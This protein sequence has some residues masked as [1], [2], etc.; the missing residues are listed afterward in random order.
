M[1]KPLSILL[2]AALSAAV[3]MIAGCGG[4]SSSGT[5]QFDTQLA[6]AKSLATSADTA[7]APLNNKI[8]DDVNTM[9]VIMTGA[10]AG[11][12][13]AVNTQQVSSITS[14]MTQLTSQIDAVKAKYQ[15][16]LNDPNL[17]TLKG[18]DQYVAY[19]QA[20]IKA[21]N[22]YKALFTAGANFLTQ[23]E[24]MLVSG[25]TAGVQAAVQAAT[26]SGQITQLQTLM[27]TAQS[28][29]AAARTIK[30]QQELGK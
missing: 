27:T 4:G 23:I 30:S 2:I 14:S 15:Q 22:D 9:T 29:L 20:M 25:N 24:P 19:A 21:L 3:L 28:D 6:K 16:L 1:K 12:P 13:S 8:T 26:S 10:I 18:P 7:W 5:N 11:N 17:K